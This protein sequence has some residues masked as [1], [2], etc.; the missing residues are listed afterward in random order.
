MPSNRKDLDGLRFRMPGSDP[1][2][3]IDRGEKRHIPNPEV[4]R[5]LFRDWRFIHLDIDIDEITTGT[6]IPENSFL[7]KCVD[8]PKV[9]LLDGTPPNQVK[10]HIV[11]PAVMERFQFNW[12]RIHRFNVPVD[13]IGI[14]DGD[15]ITKT[16]RPD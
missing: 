6:P 5:E 2:F 4:Y 1:V 15:P 7:F 16:G 11:S 10:R 9:F 8:S 3:L 14:P 13:M 12:D